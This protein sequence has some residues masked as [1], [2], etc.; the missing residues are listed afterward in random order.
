MLAT[1]H[2]IWYITRYPGDALLEAGLRGRSANVPDKPPIGEARF[3]GLV[4][5]CN[6]IA[7]NVARPL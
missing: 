5:A 7:P 6:G 2:N 3:K 4:E 1:R